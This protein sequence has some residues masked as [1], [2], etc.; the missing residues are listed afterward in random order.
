MTR[1]GAQRLRFETV[2]TGPEPGTTRCVF[3]DLN[4]LADSWQSAAGFFHE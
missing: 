1:D 4:Q 2:A 3:N